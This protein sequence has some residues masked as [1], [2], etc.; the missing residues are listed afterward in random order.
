MSLKNN[1]RLIDLFAGPGGLGEGFSRINKKSKFLPSVSIE[2]DKV[3]V[4][5]LRL[6]KLFRIATN[7]FKW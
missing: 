5:T 7:V 1:I 6:R 3:A 4:E 2:M